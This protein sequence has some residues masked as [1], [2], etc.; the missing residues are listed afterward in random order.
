MKGMKVLKGD[1]AP[2]YEF[3]DGLDQRERHRLG[4]IP[5]QWPDS[6]MHMYTLITIAPLQIS[7]SHPLRLLYSQSSH[8]LALAFYPDH[9]HLS[10]E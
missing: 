1:L 3:M 7:N 2:T 6:G 5:P 9:P 8:S 10:A 4:A